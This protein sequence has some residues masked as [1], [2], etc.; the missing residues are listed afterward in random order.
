VF[1][2]ARDFARFGLLYLRDGVWDGERVLP[3]CA[4]IAPGGLHLSVERSG[5]NYVARVSA[6]EPVN[7]Y[8]AERA[9]SAPLPLGVFEM[10]RGDNV[11]Y[12]HLVGADPRSKGLN[13]DLAEIIFER[14]K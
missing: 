3:G 5:A 2:T 10:K 1:A 7:L 13:L 8:A 9:V 14:I 6:G 12:F 4:Y 11:V